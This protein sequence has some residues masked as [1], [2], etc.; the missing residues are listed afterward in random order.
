MSPT[1]RW[2]RTTT[3][4]ATMAMA[5]TLTVLTAVVAPPVGAATLTVNTTADTVDV[6]PGN[7]LCA[8]SV[9]QCSIRAAIQEANALAGVDTIT[10]PGGTYVLSRSGRGENAAATGDLDV[11]GDLTITS[12]G[13]ATI[14][15]DGLDRALHARGAGTDLVVDGLVVVDGAPEAG[16]V[17]GGILGDVGTTLDLTVEVS[18]S[19][20]MVGGG[21]FAG[22]PLTLTG[23]L[24]TSNSATNAG[25]VA[26]L[27]PTQIIDSVLDD[28]TATKSYGGGGFAQLVTVVGS[29]ITDNQAGS[30]AGLGALASASITDTSIESN[31]AVTAVGGVALSG[32]ASTLTEVLVSGNTAGTLA[33]GVGADTDVA[34]DRTI[35]VGNSAHSGGGVVVLNASATVDGSTIADNTAGD[36][37]GLGVIGGPADTLTVASSTISGNQATGGAGTSGAG[38]GILH[39]T[40]ATLTSTTITANDT[41]VGPAGLYTLGVGELG[42]PGGTTSLANTIVADQAGTDNDCGGGGALTS[43]GHNLDTTATC[44]LTAP[45]DQAGVASADLEA[46]GDN[47]GPTPT[48]DLL[49]TSLAFDTGY[50]SCAA[51]DQRGLPRPTNGACDTGAVELQPLTLVV[52]TADDTLDANPGDGVCEDAGGDC[53]FRAA[54]EEANAASGFPTGITIEVADGVD[55]VLSRGGPAEDDNATGDLDITATEITI[56]GNGATFD[57]DDIDRHL[58]FDASPQVATIRDL[59]LT[60]GHPASGSKVG[61]SIESGDVL[62]LEA[63]TITGNRA[64]DGDATF[65]GGSGGA[66]AAAGPLTI[67]DSTIT[68]NHAGDGMDGVVGFGTLGGD[69][70][71]IYAPTDTVTIA[72]STFSGNS[73][74]DGG[75]G[76]AGGPGG[77]GG[78]GGG[79][80]APNTVTISDSTISGNRAGDG[81]A[82]GAGV[83]TGGTGGNGGFGGGALHGSGGATYTNVTLSGNEAGNGADGGP[84]SGGAGGQGGRAGSGGA[85]WAAWIDPAFS[86]AFVTIADNTYGTN[87]AGGTGSPAGPAGP[88]GGGAGIGQYNPGVAT[89]TASILTSTQ[90]PLCDQVLVSGGGNVAAGSTCGLAGAADLQNA[91]PQ[92]SALGLH[93]GPTE[94]HLPDGTSSPAIDRVTPGV[95]GCATTV[96]TD[97]RGVARPGG[98]NCDSGAVENGPATPLAL[99]VDTTADTVDAALA[100]GVCADSTGDCSLR[101]AIQE[102]NAWPATDSITLQTGATYDLT[103]AGTGEENAATGDLDITDDVTITGNGAIVDANDLDRVFHVRHSYLVVTMSALTVREG[104]PP[105]GATGAAGSGGGIRNAG[106]LTLTGVTVDANDAADAPTGIAGSCGGGIASTGKLT[107][108]NSTISNNTAGNGAQ[109]TTGAANQPGTAGTAGGHGGGICVESAQALSITNSTFTDNRNGAGGRGGDG[110]PSTSGNAHGGNGGASGNGAQLYVIG[111]GTVSLST[112]DNAGTPAAAGGRGGDGKGGGNGGNGGA[113]G[114]GG[115]VFWASSGGLDL[116]ITISTFHNHISG[117]GGSGGLAGPFSGANPDGGDGGRA[118]NGG[119]IASGSGTL[120]VTR[121]TLNNNFGGVGGDGTAGSPVGTAGTGGGGGGV[122]TNAAGTL[123]LSNSTLADNG[124]GGGGSS[125][126]GPGSGGS[127]GALSV[128]GTGTVSYTTLSG[129]NAIEVGAGSGN[130]IHSAGTLNIHT[131]VIADSIDGS[132]DCA[133]TVTSQGSNVGESTSCPF[134]VGND[135]EGTDPALGALA[136]NGGSTQTMSLGVASI[137]RDRTATGTLGCATTVTI[138]QRANARTGP[139]DSGS[140]EADVVPPLSLTVNSTTDA[141]D[142][143][144]G[145][146]VCATAAA[147]CTLRAAIQETNVYPSP[148]TDTITLAASTTYPRTIAGSSEDQ[149]TTGDLDIRDDLHI[150]GNGATVDAN[151]LDRVFHLPVAGIDVVIEDVTVTDG[152][153]PAT[154]HG[155]GILTVA[156]LELDGV[157]VSANETANGNPGGAAAFGGGIHNSGALSVTDST[158]T[159]NRAGNGGNGATGPAGGSGFPGGDGGHGG[160]IFHSAGSLTLLRTTVS[161]NLAGN[162]GNG[163]AGGNAAVGAGG[164][165][166]GGGDGGLGGGILMNGGTSTITDSR[167]ASNTAGKGGNGGT[168]GSGA[169]TGSGGAGGAGAAG[170][171]GGGLLATGTGSLG[172]TGTTISGNA[173]G[174]GGTGG[175]GGSGGSTSGNGGAGG[176]GGDAGPGGGLGAIGAPLTATMTNSTVSGNTSGAG[177]A[178]GNGGASPGVFGSDGAGGNGGGGGAGANVGVDGTT[179]TLSYLTITR[180]TVGANGAGGSGAPAGSPGTTLGGAGLAANAP[181]TVS[182]SMIVAQLSGTD[183]W[184]AV[185]SGGYNLESATSCGFTGTGD[186]QNNSGSLGAL[187]NNGGPTLT[188]LPAAGSVAVNTIP[189]GTLGCGTTVAVDQRGSVRPNGATCDKGAVER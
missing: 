90:A 126:G 124:T 35:V 171:T 57:A 61:G 31:D 25:G 19:T 96:T 1:C 22:G 5:A 186:Q 121:S 133:G 20:A 103:R 114:D 78:D 123:Q 49:P 166:A 60:G 76:A 8:D 73:A 184:S 110:G 69:G 144:P 12:P 178:G 128:L 149:A 16:A 91:D 27:A 33:G 11:T 99:V 54:V 118:G 17:G 34:L 9:G 100:D 94:T 52:D 129:N 106:D 79:I 143:L 64:R 86:F 51:T 13:S 101:A 176:E 84:G 81:G 152:R 74:G 164:V 102:S 145:D 6:A 3:L 87:G 39:A 122:W 21:V 183:C 88:V 187:A 43:L 55:P 45:G 136:N 98:T 29:T 116:S 46:L 105:A 68:D 36:V 113:G 7:G 120:A 75:S 72:R 125:P 58:H 109:G 132:A 66:I 2:H 117:D 174:A 141:V 173:S 138:D 189:V 56:E 142:A 48:H 188:H 134:N 80:F 179:A 170:G 137:A 175:A 131:S 163:G 47:G 135:I 112:F 127:G 168:G 154:Q 169:A 107:L 62:T 177:G 165:G 82:G 161:S 185:G 180:G 92:L 182:A 150:V 65:R 159:A 158:I 151:D 157:T 4:V 67:V 24:V 10:V 156:D 93:G 89:V 115:G 23:S 28:N 160:G 108:T 40:A 153:A 172:I 53:S 85:V 32:A 14:D 104:A 95:G 63:V 111:G 130:H 147:V 42:S 44:A 18:E 41:L 162:G 139:C 50:A 71:A 77:G 140:F 97:Q 119:A 30:V 59:T 167:L 15:A 83:P 148:G 181:V 26:A 38:G 37:G 146:G 155:G 70:G